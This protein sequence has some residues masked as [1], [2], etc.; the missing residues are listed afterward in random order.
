MIYSPAPPGTHLHRV[1]AELARL[2]SAS[3]SLLAA[4]IAAVPLP[5]SINRIA[6]LSIAEKA[7][8]LPIVTTIDFL[9]ARRRQGPDWHAYDSVNDDLKLATSLYDVA[10]GVLS[11]ARDISTPDQLR[12][13]RIG[14]PPRPSSVRLF[15]EALLRDGWGILD[16]V[17]LVDLTPPAVT[18]AVSSGWIDATTWNLVTI[19]P[20][21]FTP[22]FPEL[23]RRPG[24][25]WIAVSAAT[26][27]K[28][29]AANP[30]KIA[31][32]KVKAADAQ[33]M[34]LSFRQGLAVWASTPDEVVSGILEA[35]K[36]RGAEFPGLPR[37]AYDLAN[38]PLLSEALLHPAALDFFRR[39][40]IAF[41]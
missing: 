8:H 13:R 31:G 36:A 26:I 23:L 39:N 24:A 16:D 35:L 20:D 22:E 9:P 11:T 38:W 19:G 2:L 10:F 12:G 28:I 29:N 37:S 41:A 14:V 25:R 6:A 34:L 15:T 40:G 18:G 27:D 33:T 3:G 1:N 7:R 21:H 17:E 4:G 32:S 5:D 30:F